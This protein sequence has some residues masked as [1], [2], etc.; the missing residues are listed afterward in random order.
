MYQY[1]R[2]LI[3]PSAKAIEMGFRWWADGGST[4]NGGFVVLQ[5]I[6]TS[7]AKN[8]YIL[9]DFSGDVWTHCPIPTPS[10]SAHASH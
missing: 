1:T 3:G 5:G 7:I 4:L 6:R 2:T 8:S 9:C 10:G